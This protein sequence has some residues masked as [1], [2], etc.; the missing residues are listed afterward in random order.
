MWRYAVTLYG[1][2][3]VA[4]ACLALQDRHGA[5]V[6]LLLAAIWHAERGWGT[7][8]LARWRA[9]SAAWRAAAVLP[10]RSLRRALKARPGWEPIRAR[11]KRLELAAE[12]AQLAALARHARV[13]APAPARA[14]LRSVLG[15]AAR[16]APARTILTQAAKMRTGSTRFRVAS[17]KG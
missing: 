4:E 7:P 11:V 5:D 3:G 14:V 15:N 13:G 1:R 9:I 8:D 17:T 2:P 12:R 10:L 6:P 16:G